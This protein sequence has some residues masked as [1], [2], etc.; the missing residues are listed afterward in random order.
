[1]RPSKQCLRCG[2]IFFGTVREGT[3]NF[4]RRR[5]CSLKCKQASTPTIPLE[6]RFWDKVTMGDGCWEWTGTR[7]SWGYGL[8]GG[9]RKVHLRAHRV[10]WEI[11]FGP[12]PAGL[13][14]LHHCDNPRCVRPDHLFLGTHRDNMA[15]MVKK[16]RWRLNRRVA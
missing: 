6:R 7:H 2:A 5:H 14:I 1:M 16:G 10:S 8:L 12:I 9:R 3:V 4:A 15:D 11:H 13:Y